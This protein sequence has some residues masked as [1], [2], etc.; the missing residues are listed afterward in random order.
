MQRGIVGF[1]QPCAC[2]CVCVCV[3]GGEWEFD[4]LTTITVLHQFEQSTANL[5]DLYREWAKPQ[6]MTKF[7]I[8]TLVTQHSTAQWHSKCQICLYDHGCTMLSH[9]LVW[10]TS[11]LWWGGDIRKLQNYE[12]QHAVSISVPFKHRWVLCLLLYRKPV[13]IQG[14]DFW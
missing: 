8:L 5:Q 6:L 9:I 4:T 2:V 10:S 1:H 13:L 14:I 7:S 12:Q 11:I 3:C